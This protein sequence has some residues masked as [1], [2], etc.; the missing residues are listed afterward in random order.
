MIEAV[1]RA[2]A[3]AIGTIF[4]EQPDSVRS[5]FGWLPRDV[6]LSGMDSLLR[7]YGCLFS[8]LLSGKPGQFREQRAYTNRSL[9]CVTG[10]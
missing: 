8:R 5:E 9:A 2:F 10:I 7:V 1:G 4:L 6:L 3:V